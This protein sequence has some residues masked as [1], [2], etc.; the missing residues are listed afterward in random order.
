MRQPIFQPL[1]SGTLTGCGFAPAVGL[2]CVQ[3]SETDLRRYRDN[4][5]PTSY[6][7]RITNPYRAHEASR[8]AWNQSICADSS[9]IRGAIAQARERYVSP[10]MQPSSRRGLTISCVFINPLRPRH[11]CFASPIVPHNELR[12][13]IH[14]PS[15]SLSSY[16]RAGSRSAL[17]SLNQD[18]QPRRSRSLRHDSV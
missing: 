11:T 16:F 18:T 7:S 4:F 17:R 9:L 1:L 15:V 13:A 2:P 6:T 10:C 5:E 12:R 8:V 3:G 14:S